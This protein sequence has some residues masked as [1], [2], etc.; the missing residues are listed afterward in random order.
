MVTEEL[1]KVGYDAEEEYFYKLNQEIIESHRAALAEERAKGRH[2]QARTEHW[3]K[4]PKCGSEMSEM[5]FSGITTDRCEGCGGIF[6]DQG[7]IDLLLK[8]KEPHRF[9][10]G[11]KRFWEESWKVRSTG[12]S[13]FPI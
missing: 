8:S 12:I 7:E 9:L 10:E 6:F 4:C 1:K 2:E 11:L 13:N 3:M 5:D